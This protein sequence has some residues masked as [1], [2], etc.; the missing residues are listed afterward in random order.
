[1]KADLPTTSDIQDAIKDEVKVAAAPKATKDAAAL[2]AVRVT[3]KQ[4]DYVCE[5]IRFSTKPFQ[6]FAGAALLESLAKDEN[7]LVEELK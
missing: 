1:M 7:L 6:F 3:A 5:G 4:S 2:V